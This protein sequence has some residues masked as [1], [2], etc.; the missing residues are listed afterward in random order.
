MV[1]FIVNE[2]ILLTLGKNGR[3][4]FFKKKKKEKKI[5]ILT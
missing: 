4:Y 1:D 3:V 5:I 2:K